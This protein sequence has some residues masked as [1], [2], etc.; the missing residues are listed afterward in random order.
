M[1]SSLAYIGLVGFLVTCLSCAE[2]NYRL[3]MPL[4][5]KYFLTDS[6]HQAFCPLT[7][8][9][10]LKILKRTPNSLPRA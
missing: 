5:L 1:S 10:Y 2:R 3:S 8:S 9:G 7:Q 6:G 4:G